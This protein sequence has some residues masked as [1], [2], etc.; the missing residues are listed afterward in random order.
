MN[1]FSYLCQRN[2]KYTTDMKQNCMTHPLLT[3]VVA[4]L[5]LCSFSACRQKSSPGEGKQLSAQDYAIKAAAD[6]IAMEPEK[7]VEDTSL[8]TYAMAMEI[9]QP[10]YKCDEKFFAS[11]FGDLGLPLQFSERYNSDADWG[12]DS[13]AISYCWG[14]N[15]KYEEYKFTA[16]DTP[17]FGTHFNL[18]LDESGKT[19][20][21]RQFTIIT[22]NG[23]WYEKFFNDMQADGLKYVSKV[24]P[25][26][27]GKK[28]KM[29]H[30]KGEPNEHTTEQPFYYVYDFSVE[31]VYEVE[32][33]YD[34]G[35]DI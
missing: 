18:F 24:D 19:G 20:R 13:Q 6:S 3:L 28:G 21:V 11:L 31:G 5:V 15:V 17:Y 27:Y 26:V 14:N 8:F 35:M 22:S 9:V 30:K 10:G 1:Y 4:A 12:G 32:V 23:A 33:G 7:A 25:D 2:N 34:D 29:Y 16:T